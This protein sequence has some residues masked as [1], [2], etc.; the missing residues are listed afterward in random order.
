MRF[1]VLASGSS[2]NAIYL[3]S[4]KT[5]LLV[6][7]GLSGKEVTKRLALRGLDP[8]HLDG[9]LVT[10]E[11]HDHILGVGVL[12]RK[13]NLPVYI[14][15][16]TLAASK[17]RMGWLPQT[18]SFETGSL[19]QTGAFSVTPFAIPHDAAC[20]VGFTFSSRGKKVGLATDMGFVPDP[21]KAR[22]KDVQ[23]LILESNHDLKML[24]EGP[25]A[26]SL[27]QR[28]MSRQGH[29]SN[30]EAGELL[31]ELLHRDLENVVLA[32]ISKV[33]N[34]PRLAYRT[35]EAVIR[36][37]G[38]STILGTVGQGEMGDWV[39]VQHASR[40]RR[41]LHQPPLL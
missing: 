37:Y 38:A 2:G 20:P 30:V 19:F 23:A 15:P 9:I 33:N 16:K 8:A 28:V 13:Y 24:E 34:D 36:E 35:A 5:K 39:E 4:E 18:I 32:H 3:E 29:L 27:K 12:S 25:Y 17:G 26:W 10:H 1:C 31:G 21:V 22:L 11:H 40:N 14:H 6:D 7:C 41:K